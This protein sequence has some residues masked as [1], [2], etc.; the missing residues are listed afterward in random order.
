VLLLNA[1]YE[2]APMLREAARRST[3]SVRGARVLLTSWWDVPPREQIVALFPGAFP[4]MDLEHA[5]L[6]ETSLMLHLAPERVGPREQFPDVLAS[7]PGYELYPESLQ[8]A[9]VGE[10]SLAPASAASAEI[11]ERLVSLVVEGVRAAVCKTLE[12]EG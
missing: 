9:A 5:G 4:G 3:S 6:L 2:N 10:G 7:P 12:T 1:H 8:R 11:G